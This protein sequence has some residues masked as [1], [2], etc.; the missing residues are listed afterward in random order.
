MCV[1][2]LLNSTVRELLCQ[3]RPQSTSE[4]G[5][6]DSQNEV[7]APLRTELSEEMNMPQSRTKTANPVSTNPSVQV[8]P[9]KSIE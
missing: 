4:D 6:V 2:T 3:A 9:G 5:N 8:L 7:N 1:C